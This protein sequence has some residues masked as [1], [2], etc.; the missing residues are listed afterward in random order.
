MLPFVA[1]FGQSV[2]GETTSTPILVALIVAGFAL[3]G[4]AASIVQT[5]RIAKS[6]HKVEE[7]KTDLADFQ[8]MKKT[9]KEEIADLRADLRDALADLRDARLRIG[10][11]EA[12]NRHLMEQLGLQARPPDTR[13]RE[14][15][16]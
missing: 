13:E 8:E 2:L 11:L 5:S 12:E 7:S 16:G 14:T 3:L 15:D 1:I 10:D 9:W 6:T 4:T